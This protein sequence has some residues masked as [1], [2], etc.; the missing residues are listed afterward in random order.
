MTK[1]FTEVGWVSLYWRVLTLHCLDIRLYV[2][3]ASAASWCLQSSR[4]FRGSSATITLPLT[5]ARIFSQATSIDS[6]ASFGKQEGGRNSGRSS[7]RS[8]ASQSFRKAASTSSPI[9][10]HVHV[11]GRTL[12]EANRV[13]RNWDF[14]KCPAPRGRAEERTMHKFTQSKGHADCG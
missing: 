12:D 3:V 7:G 6:D 4:E 9:P 14:Q 10:I 5:W 2:S 13:R 1:L 8:K 11:S